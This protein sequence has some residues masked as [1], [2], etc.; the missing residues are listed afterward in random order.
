MS[1]KPKRKDPIEKLIGIVT[2]KAQAEMN[3][4]LDSLGSHIEEIFHPIR[5]RKEPVIE[6]ENPFSTSKSFTF[7]V[8]PQNEKTRFEKAKDITPKVRRSTE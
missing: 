2:E 7:K 5:K 1:R 3:T 6:K 4:L 8:E